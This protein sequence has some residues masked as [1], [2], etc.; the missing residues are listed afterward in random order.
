VGVDPQ[1]KF[2]SKVELKRNGVTVPHLRTKKE[3]AG[4]W[5]SQNIRIKAHRRAGCRAPRDEL[6]AV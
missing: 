2:T 5:R 1:A 4:A 6:A 3:E